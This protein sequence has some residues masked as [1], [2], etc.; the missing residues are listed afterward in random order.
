MK[1]LPFGLWPVGKKCFFECG[2]DVEHLHHMTLKNYYR[3]RSWFFH[4][5]NWNFLRVN[6]NE[7]DCGLCNGCFSTGVRWRRNIVTGDIVKLVVRKKVTVAHRFVPRSAVSTLTSCACGRTMTH[8][9][10]RFWLVC[11]SNIHASFDGLGFN[12]RPPLAKYVLG[13][14]GHVVWTRSSQLSSVLVFILRP[15]ACCTTHHIQPRAL[16]SND[17]VRPQRFIRILASSTT[18][19]SRRAKLNPT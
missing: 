3:G 8:L 19:H 12:W 5:L 1:W 10:T 11:F 17:T 7:N 14:V 15:V 2:V 4:L 13:V 18:N 16:I 9:A 6:H